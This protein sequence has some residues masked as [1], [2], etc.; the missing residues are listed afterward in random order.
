MHAY[1]TFPQKNWG[2]GLSKVRELMASRD[3]ALTACFLTTCQPCG[4]GLCRM[5]TQGDHD[6]LLLRSLEGQVGEPQA[7]VPR[8]IDAVFHSC[9]EYTRRGMWHS[10]C[11]CIL[12]IVCEPCES[13]S[14]VL[15]GLPLNLQD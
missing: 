11:W 12:G 9:T 5:K 15:V 6:E 1:L 13:N 7:Y 4:L 10:G 14:E 8:Q 2:Q 3:P